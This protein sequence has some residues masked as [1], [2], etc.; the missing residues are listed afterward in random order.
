M[1][2]ESGGNKATNWPLKSLWDLMRAHAILEC[3][4]GSVEWSSFKGPNWN[5]KG[6][7]ATHFLSVNY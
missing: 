7:M 4:K 6:N 5:K 2:W 1:I 3:H